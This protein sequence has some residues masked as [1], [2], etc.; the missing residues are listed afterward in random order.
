MRRKPKSVTYSK[1][2]KES[3]ALYGTSTIT[4]EQAVEAG[5]MFYW[6]GTPCIKG[7]VTFRYV[8]NNNCRQCTIDRNE[9]KNFGPKGE[10]TKGKVETKLYEL[11][12]SRLNGDLDY[13]F[14]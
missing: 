3:V 4:L 13:E 12:L 7:H 1:F 10:N 8:S 9:L 14:D 6:T 2:I 5:L 11:E